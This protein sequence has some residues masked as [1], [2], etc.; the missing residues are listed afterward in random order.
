MPKG[1]PPINPTSALPA[2][3]RKTENKSADRLCCR[4]FLFW[5]ILESHRHLLRYSALLHRDSIQDI[6]G[7]HRSLLV[8]HHNELR[9]VEEFLQDTGEPGCV[10]LVECGID[11]VQN[12][13]RAR[14]AAKNGK[15]K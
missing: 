15:Q 11:L 3:W 12:A 9:P 14:P 10:R 5:P 13:E 6:G 7:S 8:R 2:V 1:M 4:L